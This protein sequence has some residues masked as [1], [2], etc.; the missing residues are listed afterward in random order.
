MHQGEHT[1]V[2]APRSHRATGDS[3]LRLLDRPISGADLAANAELAARPVH[4]RTG[5]M[6]GVVVFQLGAELAALP[7]TLLRRV[8]PVAQARPIPHRSSPVF[9]GVCNIRG[10][11]V[12]C[13]DLRAMLGVPAREPS[14]APGDGVSDPHRMVVI[15]SPDDSWAFEADGVLGVESVELSELRSPPVT[16]AY[17]LGAYTMGIADIGGR[18]V[19]VL[20]GDRILTGF[21][22]GLS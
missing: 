9:R 7:A 19:T 2:N 18:S 13:A 20:D 17:A 8:T 10:E 12:L 21:K 14:D 11:L 3:I 5:R 1:S 15:G 22:A 6:S 4:A 16:V